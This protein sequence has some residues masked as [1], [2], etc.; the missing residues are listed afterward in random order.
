MEKQQNR[1]PLQEYGDRSVL[2]TWTMSYEQV[3]KQSQNAAYLL[4]LWGFLD[5]GELWYEL[6]AACR[7]LTIDID[8][9]TW[10]LE[11]AEDELS[12]VDVMGLLARYSL[13][14]GKEGTDSYSMHGVLH[15]WCSSQAR[16]KEWQKLGCLAAELVALR[17]P[18]EW[19][20]ETWR[21][22]KRIIGHG[23]YV[24]SWIVEGRTLSEK[25][26]I[27]TLIQPR[28][29][30]RLGNLLSDEDRQRAEHMYQ[31]ALAGFEKAWGPDHTETL[32]TVNN[33]GILY[34]DLGKLEQAEQMYKRAL[35][36]KEKTWGPDH[37]S[38]LTAVDNLGRLYKSL[39]RLKEAE[40][41][42][43]RALAGYEKAWGPDHTSTL[44][45]VNN[46]GL[47]YKDLGKVE[48]AE[49]MLQ[50][51]LAGYEKA[52]G[53]DH[54]STIGIIHN[55]CN[56]YKALG[57]SER[58]EQMYQRA[59]ARYEEACGSDHTE[60]LNT[61]HCLG[62]LYI[63]LGKFE[64]AEQMYQR[65]L[66][67][68]E[69]TYGPD[70]KETL[71]TVNNLGNLYKALGKLEE[72]EQ[73][74]Q[75]ALAGY[76][77]AVHPDSLLTFVPALNNMWAFASLRESQGCVDDARHW[78]LQAL[79]GYEKTFGQEHDKCQALRDNLEALAMDKEEEEEEEKEEE[80]ER[81]SLD[82]STNRSLVVD[83]ISMQSEVDL[84]TSA[85]KPASKRN[86]LLRKLRWK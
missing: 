29:F 52:L 50:R 73:M 69:K 66:A 43:Q 10:L 78:Y 72:A 2:T 70:H 58:A 34:A 33:L 62:N 40:Q 84:R 49:Q 9:P 59:L 26:D 82:V 39:D 46:L 85:T 61:V 18:F 77:K 25:Q 71:G 53:P 68:F 17:A 79:L 55:L 57:K 75:R 28:T 80:E 60:T 14:D 12:F 37:T 38:T 65:A 8:V 76:A 48:Q 36:G 35:A 51:A 13:V 22:R 16:N 27:E 15:R 74:Y 81:G 41:M 21:K 86:R 19:K 67:S 6:I 44:R 3:Q 45:T 1:F 24:C 56:L 63:S 54:T 32:H 7:D 47:L 31:R 23:V 42:Y 4:E 20:T 5:N 11:T 30:R 64:L 83:H